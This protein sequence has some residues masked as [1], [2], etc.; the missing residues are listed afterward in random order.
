MVSKSTPVIEAT[1]LDGAAVIYM[2]KPAGC[3]T[4]KEYADDILLSYITTQLATVSRVD[5]TWDRYQIDSLKQPTRELRIHGERVQQ[6]RV[7]SVFS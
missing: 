7:L 5:I 2:L 6:R 3:R 1:L 4:F